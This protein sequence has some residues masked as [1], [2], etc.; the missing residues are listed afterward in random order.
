MDG[1]HNKFEK[2]SE[3]QAKEFEK[4]RGQFYKSKRGDD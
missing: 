3:G 4:D 2:K 1:F